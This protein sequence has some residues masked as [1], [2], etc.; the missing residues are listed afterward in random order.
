[1]PVAAGSAP[2]TIGRRNRVARGFVLLLL[3]LAVA[4]AATPPSYGRDPGFRF[5][6]RIEGEDS[7]FEEASGLDA[8]A[9]ADN[10]RGGGAVH[11]MRGQRA[12]SSVVLREGIVSGALFYWAEQSKL[13]GAKRK[14]VVITLRNPQGR[15]LRVWTLTNAWPVKL[16]A[17]AVSASGNDIVVETVEIDYQEATVSAP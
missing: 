12:S 11:T 8:A 5:V 6:V 16:E 3:A 14:T 13:G 17:G 9:N 1:M 15:P 10:R 4:T 2:E 7:Y